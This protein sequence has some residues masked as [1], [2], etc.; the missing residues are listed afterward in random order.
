M[1]DSPSP[2]PIIGAARHISLDSSAQECMEL[3][4]TWFHDCWWNHSCGSK[5]G[6]LPTRVLQLNR[7]D[8]TVYLLEPEGRVK[9]PFVALSHCWGKAIPIKTTKGNLEK[10]KQGIPVIDLPKTFQ[11]AV[12][13]CR[14]MR[15]HYL[16]IDSLCIIQDSEEDW[17]QEAANMARVY[18]AA[19]FTIAAHS[20][21][22]STGGCFVPRSNAGEEPFSTVEYVGPKNE[23]GSVFIRLEP[24]GCPH[25][26]HLSEDLPQS[27]KTGPSKLSTRGWV[28]QERLLSR[29][30]L[31]YTPYELVFECDEGFR[32]ECTLT[33]SGLPVGLVKYKR[34]YIERLLHS[35]LKPLSIADYT[36]SDAFLAY[37]LQKIMDIKDRNPRMELDWP[38]VVEEYTRLD[39]T[40][41]SDRLPA[42]YG[43]AGARER[44]IKTP[45][46]KNQYLFGLWRDNLLPGLLWQVGTR[47]YLSADKYVSKRQPSSYAPTW[48]WA[49]VTGPVR[50]DDDFRTVDYSD[51][52]KLQPYRER[53]NIIEVKATPSTNHPFGPGMGSI[54]FMCPLVPLRLKHIGTLD[55]F[56]SKSFIAASKKAIPGEDRCPFGF[57]F[58][59]TDDDQNE[60]FFMILSHIGLQ[61]IHK[62]GRKA[63]G[64]VV[65]KCGESRFT[66]IGFMHNPQYDLRDW[67]DVAEMAIAILQ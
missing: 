53:F 4:K 32:C 27:R 56:C 39:L 1:A 11:D 54:T 12:T 48:S 7:D 42:L 66:R 16:W 5:Y 43:L 65:K 9:E 59:Q 33:H 14:E 13:I 57:E 67:E 30:T 20:A 8:D 10:H 45:A 2:W 55:D 35:N 29:R 63:V 58:S 3:A 22:D 40:F 34:R 60:Y 28:F 50:Y 51:P 24:P 49:S 37:S 15:K 41:A 25:G 52:K 17:E 21:S 31:H 46:H 26:D 36:D 38:S 19:D 6:P 47:N 62:Y 61:G 18:A 64:L 44:V 23:R